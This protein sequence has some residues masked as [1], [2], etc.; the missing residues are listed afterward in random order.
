MNVKRT[1]GSWDDSGDNVCPSVLWKAA[2][3]GLGACISLGWYNGKGD[4]TVRLWRGEH[5][6]GRSWKIKGWLDQSHM[7]RSH[8]PEQICFGYCP[9]SPCCYCRISCTSL[10]GNRAWKHVNCLVYI[11]TYMRQGVLCSPRQCST[12]G[13]NTPISEPAV[14]LSVML[15]LGGQL[16][17]P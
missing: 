10:G 7:S 16:L 12:R 3:R 9:A 14:N 17:L 4:V 1:V 6:A 5:D 15:F 2:R 13:K 11:T 8:F